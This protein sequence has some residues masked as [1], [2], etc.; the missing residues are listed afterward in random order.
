MPLARL[1]FGFVDD[2]GGRTVRFIEYTVEVFMMTYVAFRT[3]LFTQ[4]QG[5]RTIYGVVSAQIYF[6]GYQ[7]LPLIT[8]LGLAS[9]GIVVMQSTTQLSLVGGTGMMGNL[10]AAIVVRE[11]APLITALIVVARSGA[12][13]TS[14]IGN[15][16]VNR[17]IQALEAMGINP[18]SY[19]VFPR[20]VG[21]VISNLCLAFYYIVIAL[22][23]GYF[24]TRVQQEMPFFYYVD[25]LVAAFSFDDV[26][27]FLLKN[28]FDGLIIAMVCCYQGL[29]VGRSPT[30]VP[31]ATTRAVV[32]SIGYTVGFNLVVTVLFYL[33]SL[34]RMGIL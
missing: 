27:I 7:A 28:T 30:E 12:A 6:T 8:V 21:G 33:K 11:L 32:D 20:V 25:S 10:L 22:L 24:V 4:T 15:M 14:E 18:I 16:R 26:Y 31:Q 29:Q 3:V 13:V 19:I 2:V 9:G 34:M 5:F 1:F 23:G 17:E